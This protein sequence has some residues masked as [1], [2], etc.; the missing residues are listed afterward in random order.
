[1]WEARHVMFTEL[2]GA[3]TA[4]FLLPVLAAVASGCDYLPFLEHY[5]FTER[6]VALLLWCS[7]VRLSVWPSETSMHCDHTV[8]F[9]VDLSLWLGRPLFRAP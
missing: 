8:H 6:I 4:I 1:M 5:A 9:N 2:I 3:V 7:S